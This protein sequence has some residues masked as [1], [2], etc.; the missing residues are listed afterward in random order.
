MKTVLQVLTYI[1]TVDATRCC[2]VNS[3]THIEIF[4]QLKLLFIFLATVS[5][6]TN[7]N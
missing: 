3:E 7:Q 6:E 2:Y 4:V 5:V 1:A